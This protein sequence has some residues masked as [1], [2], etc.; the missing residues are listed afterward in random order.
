[1][2]AIKRITLG[3]SLATIIGPLLVGCGGDPT[4]TPTLTPAPT[5]ALAAPTLMPTTTPGPKIQVVTTTSILADLVKNVGGDRVEVQS[6]VP[7][8]ADIH[9]FQSTPKH[10][11]AVSKAGVIV[12]NGFSLDAFLDPLLKSAKRSDAIHV[13]AAEGLEPMALPAQD[14]KSPPHF[15]QNP[16]HVV[17]YVERIR[18]GLV[19]ADPDNVQV[20]Q[21]NADAYIQ[22]LR[23]L[24]QE[25]AEA[26]K[27]V[28]PERR[29][30]VTFH[31]AFGYFAGR[32]GWKVS[33]FVPGDAGDMTPGAVARVMERIQEE[34]IPAVFAEPQFNPDVL[35]QAAKD[36]GGRVGV[37]YSDALDARV[38]TYIDMMRF[39]VRSLVE[40]LR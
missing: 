19:Q 36:T 32:Y 1:M 33:T 40:H 15:W 4:P 14:G 31:N 39:N 25:I 5:P 8:G 28:P 27:A 17:Y 29:H 2:I 26:L 37:I 3:L 30:L 22:K 23:E 18:D 16:L 21:A 10:S 38:P 9:S 34:G 20:Y 12:S 35:E 7:S 13:V 11:V 24:D 6:I